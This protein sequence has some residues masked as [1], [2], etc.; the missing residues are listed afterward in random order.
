MNV[1]E[2]IKAVSNSTGY[3]QK[4]ITEVFEAA[5]SV[6]ISELKNDNAVKVFKSLT[7]YPIVREAHKSR[8]PT[9]EIVDLPDTRIPKAKFS[10]ALKGLLNNK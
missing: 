5:E 6:M 1:K 3:T 2:F 7:V 8:I 9:G 4:N 10:R